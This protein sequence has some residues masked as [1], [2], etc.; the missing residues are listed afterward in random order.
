MSSFGV[1]E[2]H[3]QRFLLEPV[4]GWV[5]LNQDQDIDQPLRIKPVEIG[6]HKSTSEILVEVHEEVPTSAQLSTMFFF[7]PDQVNFCWKKGPKHSSE[8]NSATSKSKNCWFCYSQ[9]LD[10]LVSILPYS[11][12]HITICV[13]YVPLIFASFTTNVA[14][15]WVPCP[16]I[17]PRHCPAQSAQVI[18]PGPR[19]LWALWA[20]HHE[21][22]RNNMI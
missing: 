15:I 22:F 21:E 4:F 19:I 17:H 18:R 5:W 6:S 13:S 9:T 20:G 11:T 7:P 8:P 2:H 3:F 12:T 14:M 10:D 16:K 1:F